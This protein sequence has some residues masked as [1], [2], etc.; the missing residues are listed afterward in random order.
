MPLGTPLGKLVFD[1]GG[2]IPNGKKFKGALLGGPSGGVIPIEAINT[3]IDYESVTAQG[4]IMGS[5]GVVVMDENNCMVDIV[6]NSFLQFTSDESCGKC[7]PCRAGI[8]QCWQY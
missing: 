3:P 6:K 1:I 7:T 5:G 8:P 2:G 4:A